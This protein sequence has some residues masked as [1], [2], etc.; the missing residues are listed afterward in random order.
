[1]PTGA[2]DRVGAAPQVDPAFLAARAGDGGPDVVDDLLVEVV[3]EGPQV[4]PAQR[5][6]VGQ[7]RGP[8]PRL[9]RQLQHGG[10]D[11]H[12]ALAVAGQDDPALLGGEP[13]GPV[14]ELG[15]DPLGVA[16]A[17]PAGASRAARTWR[18]PRRRRQQYDECVQNPRL[19]SNSQ[20]RMIVR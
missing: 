15:H 8:G 9:G 5:R 12:R 3:R 4:E 13:G 17:A 6:A 16:R 11:Q 10:G 19:S 18:G 2:A 20:S 1:M 7:Q 14:H